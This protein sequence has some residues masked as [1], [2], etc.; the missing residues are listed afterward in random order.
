[1]AA[2]P[3]QVQSFEL[4]PCRRKEILGKLTAAVGLAIKKA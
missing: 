2:M 4:A 3:G 1:M